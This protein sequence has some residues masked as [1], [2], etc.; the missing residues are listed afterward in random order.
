MEISN[1]KAIDLIDSPSVRCNGPTSA[2]S[3]AVITHPIVR[4]GWLSFQALTMAHLSSVIDMRTESD[5]GL[6]R[7]T[8]DHGAW[9]VVL[10]A[11]GVCDLG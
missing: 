6:G 11:Q 8:F 1:L 7:K 3:S 9:K 10:E 2:Q 5:V 4:N